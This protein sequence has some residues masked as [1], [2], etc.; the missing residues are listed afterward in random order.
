MSAADVIYALSV[1]GS[2]VGVGAVFYMVGVIA[3]KRRW[4][5]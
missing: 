3:D 2:I 5:L 4:R 1:V